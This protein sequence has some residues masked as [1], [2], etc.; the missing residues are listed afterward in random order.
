MKLAEYH[1]ITKPK[2]KHKYG[3]KACIVTED[4]TLFTVE[5]IKDH[6]LNVTGTRFDSKA[7]AAYYLSLKDLQAQGQIKTIEL[8]P[9]FVLQES[10]KIKYVADF[11]VTWADDRVEVLDVK[12]M[13]NSL[14]KLKMRLFKAKF[15]DESLWLVK[16]K[17]REWQIKEVG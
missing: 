17:G 8:Q 9:V 3:A 13:E 11:R 4:L 14:F 15:P 10:P 16:R 6:K 12:G 2:K 5:D 7:E 1:K